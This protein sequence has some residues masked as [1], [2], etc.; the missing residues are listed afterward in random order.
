VI[1]RYL[2]IVALIGVVAIVAAAC[3]GDEAEAPPSPAGGDIQAGGVIKMGISAD[4]DEAFDPAK[5]YSQISWSI[6]NCCLLRTLLQYNGLDAA[7]GGSEV[8]PDLA[9]DLPELSDDGLVYTFH[10]KDGVTFG[11]PFED[12]EITSAD[13][14]R[15]IE[16]EACTV[17][18]EGGYAFYYTDNSEGDSLIE[19]IQEFAEGKADSISGL[20]TPDDKTLVITL[21][22]ATGDFPLRM[23]M[24]AMAPIPEGAAEGHDRDYG[25]FLVSSGPY[26]WEGADQLD[27]SVPA[28]QQKPVSGYD[29]GRSWELVRNPSYDPATDDLRS[30]YLDGVQVEINESTDVNFNKWESGEIDYVYDG[31]P[32][33]E[34]LQQYSTD[35]QLQEQLK[36][37][38]TDGLRYLS[39]NIAEP[40]FD[41]IHVRKAMNYIIDKDALRRARGGDLYGG[42]AGHIVPDTILGGVLADYDPYAT[43]G[44]Q[45][46]IELAKE[47]MSQSKYDSNGDG[48]C[49]APEC[50]SVPLIAD[51]ETPYPEQNAIIADNAAQIGIDFKVSEG[52]RYTF[53]YEKCLDPGAHAAFCPSVG[54]F[55]D[56]GDAFTFGPPILGSVGIG[57]EGCCNYS[58]VGASPQVLKEHGYKVTEVPSLDAQMAECAT[59]PLGDERT[60]CWAEWDRTTME[61]VVPF[62][63]WI[64]DNEVRLAGPRIV[65]YTY[66]SNQGTMALQHVALV[67]GGA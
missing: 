16:R 9:T 52:D 50:N 12:V 41:D 20:E 57:P 30:S 60:N 3:G 2:R 31:V 22:E 33:P 61:D 26:M 13:F 27:F 34:L 45:G 4:V 47:E 59:L 54:W 38:P 53:M 67:N 32:P 15:A 36:V 58:L 19:G 51:R 29:P 44:G 49:D 11:P 62:V 23:A 55:K 65:N 14:V 56:Y 28:K 5:E 63:P 18:H 39:M 21:T 35:P 40:P 24:P 37:N 8:M 64:F 48:V 7:N 10:I 25:R 1:R 42:I 6:F 46:D 66:S 43:E 17:C